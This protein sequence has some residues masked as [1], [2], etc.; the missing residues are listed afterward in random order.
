[1]QIVILMPWALMN[2][3]NI[4]AELSNRKSKISFTIQFRQLFRSPH[5]HPGTGEM[6]AGDLS[7]RHGPAQQRAERKGAL[8]AAFEE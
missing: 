8:T 2:G 7:V 5:V 1:M 3:S 6:L 4:C